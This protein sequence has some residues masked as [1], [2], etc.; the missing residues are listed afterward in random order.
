M[1]N[2]FCRRSCNLL[3][4][5]IF[6]LR[7]YYKLSNSLI[8]IDDDCSASSYRFL[9]FSSSFNLIKL[10][11]VSNYCWASLHV[12]LS[13][14]FL[15][16]QDFWRTVSYSI[17]SLIIFNVYSGFIDYSLIALMWSTIMFVESS[18]C[19]FNISSS[20]KIIDY[21]KLLLSF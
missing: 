19:V 4:Y 12:Y 20:S 7:L 11:V 14:I 15:V 3:S 16:S 18:L 21:F 9:N 13:P 1:E 17:F 5:C 6:V 2:V 10:N 8:F